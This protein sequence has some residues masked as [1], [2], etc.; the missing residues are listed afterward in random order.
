MNFKSLI[1]PAAVILSACSQRQ[2]PA[3]ESQFTPEPIPAERMHIADLPPMNTVLKA[4]AFR[5]S[6]DYAD[7]VAVSVGANGQLTY[8]PAPSD[9]TPASR[10]VALKD[11]WYLNRQ[12]LGP[13]SSFTRYSF[14][15]YAA[16]KAVPSPSELLE[17][18]IPDA[19]VT[20][21]VTLDIPASDAARNPS[22]LLPLLPK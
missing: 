22:L 8:F 16:L 4:T 6:G 7:K 15:E 2:Q 9:I 18:I 19:V 1:L 13:G 17:S 5:M 11:G 21:F 20:D 3:A 14:E 10:P 12:G